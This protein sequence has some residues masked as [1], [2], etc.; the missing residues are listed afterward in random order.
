MI[1]YYVKYAAEDSDRPDYPV[2]DGVAFRFRENAEKHSR[3][4]KGS[5]IVKRDS[6]WFTVNDF[7]EEPHPPARRA[8]GGSVARS[9]LRTITGDRYMRTKRVRGPSRGAFGWMRPPG[10]GV[11]NYQDPSGKHAPRIYTGAAK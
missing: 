4:R 8:R 1:V 3:E 2:I 10:G 11:V 7:A 5:K 9:I 6:P